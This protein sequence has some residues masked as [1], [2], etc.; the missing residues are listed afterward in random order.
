M[1]PAAE[2]L[3]KCIVE[4]CSDR[5]MDHYLSW[6]EIADSQDYEEIKAEVIGAVSL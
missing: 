4:C 3:L 5:D 6:I 2:R 1:S